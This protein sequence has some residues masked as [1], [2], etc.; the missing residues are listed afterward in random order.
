MRKIRIL[1]NGD[2]ITDTIRTKQVQMYRQE[3]R[4]NLI[5]KEE[6]EILE[7]TDSML[8]VGY[9]Y[10][11]A[12]RL[13]AEEPG[14]YL[15]LNRAVDG[16]RIAD[17]DARLY[18]D[19][20][21]LK[22]DVISLLIGVNDAWRS[23]DPS[24]NGAGAGKF[25]KMYDTL[26]SDIKEALPETELILMEPYILAGSA[27]G[28]KLSYFREV[29]GTYS[30]VVRKMADR[31]GAELIRTQDLFDE[32]VRKTSGDVSHWVVDGVHPTAAGHYL[33]AQAWI[34]VLKETLRG[35]KAG[36]GS[37]QA[38]GNAAKDRRKLP[39]G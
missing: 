2:S 15:F 10:L 25:E 13:E 26:L 38:A 8:G 18:S 12:A 22:P 33:L 31:Y 5:R 11:A 3:L 19:M 28:D 9:P 6:R 29:V 36:T 27:V 4:E 21:N 37:T 7:D 32:A 20:I 17:V 34:P 35:G 24:C 16:N 23:I 39:G 1:F 14:R 30:L